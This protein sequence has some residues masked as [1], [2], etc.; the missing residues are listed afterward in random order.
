[1]NVIWYLF[2]CGSF[3]GSAYVISKNEENKRLR[4]ILRAKENEAEPVRQFI[5][6]TA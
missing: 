2:V 1:M 4:A 3:F 5:N 6:M